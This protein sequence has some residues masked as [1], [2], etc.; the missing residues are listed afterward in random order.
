MRKRL[1]LAFAFIALVFLAFATFSF[2][3]VFGNVRGIV[4]DPQH[5]PI[6]G[7]TVQV[8]AV[9]SDFQQ[10]AQTDVDGSFSFPAVP[11]GDYAVSVSASGFGTKE[12][13]VTL[14]SDT[15]SV[16]HFE[17]ALATVSET[18]VVTAN[19][20]TSELQTVTPTSLVNGGDIERTPG[21]DLTNSLAMITDFT[22]G[23]YMTH[24]MLHMRG[25]HQ[26]SWL[27]DGV[28]I[29]DTNIGTSIGPRIAPGDIDET[30]IL[31]GSYNAQYGD[32]TYGEFN[33][34][35]KTGFDRNNEG[36]LAVTLGNYYQ[37]DDQI[38][39][40]SH[41]QKLGYYA[42]V[43]ANRS[44]YGLEPPIPQTFHDAENGFGG[45][46]SLT[47][48]LDPKNQ[49]R[50]DGQVR[51]DYYQIPYDP[52]PGDFENSQW[53]TS[54]LRDN[55]T[56]ADGYALF[57]WV[58]TFNP[59]TVLTVSP[60]YHYNDAVYNGPMTDFPVATNAQFQT[61]YGGG[62]AVLAF[63]LPRNDVQVGTYAFGAGQNENFSLLFT[64]GTSSGAALH[65]T[66]PGDD[67]AAYASDKF[68]VNS[69]LTFIAGVRS[70][71]F[72][73]GVTE[74][75]TSPRVGGTLKIPR[76]NWVFRAFWGKYYQP[77]PLVSISGALL[78]LLQPTCD[79]S[80][81]NCFVPLRGERDQEHQFGVT[82][83][84]R[85]WTLDVDNF[86]TRAVNF[87]DH[88]NLGESSLF[89][90][91]TIAQ[92]RI[93]GT[94]VTLRSPRMWNRMQ[95]HLAYSNQMAEARGAFT[96][97]LIVGAPDSLTDW[98]KLDHDQRNTL[99]LGA[100]VNLR[101]QSYLSGN[102]YYGSGFSN[103]EAGVPGSPFQADYLP[104]HSQVDLGIGK[105]IGERLFV[106]VNATNITDQRILLDNS[107]TFGGFHYNNPLEV[108]AQ[109]RWKFHY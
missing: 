103:G 48:N 105:R 43:N 77:P 83:P 17:L 23:A 30:E 94:E 38:S 20:G 37:T 59:D 76:A 11:F 104:G 78:S 3:T 32:R 24:D 61:N 1:P 99:N 4:H 107:L 57:S 96:G 93:N 42:S 86:S 16:L 56:E 51:R 12:Q 22:P 109:V 6:A 31:R 9:G 49:L 54:Q 90:P 102:F 74:N 106:A 84:V 69:W 40:G 87:L 13:R 21:A 67:I 26:T 8:K 7:A 81:P 80:D 14:A 2:A 70:T 72:S 45:F 53:P 52:D 98:G 46:T 5:K 66:V 19:A 62:Q 71:H 10:S 41:T 63:H 82:I 55:E 75:A 97:G 25:G 44:N 108:Y 65:A 101:W 91:V 28:P 89:I 29:P 79:P 33:I 35:P 100:D 36:E 88:N 68:T 18:A 60:F 50:F 15:S 34:L 95:V 85:G 47:Y 39:F 27:I 92:A 64:D 58:H 73:G